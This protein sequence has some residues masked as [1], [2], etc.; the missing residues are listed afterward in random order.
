M[1]EHYV[2]GFEVGTMKLQHRYSSQAR[3]SASGKSGAEGVHRKTAPQNQAGADGCRN[4]I[5]HTCQQA[6]DAFPDKM[7]RVVIVKQKAK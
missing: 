3:K 5:R 4:G 1:P 7:L 6:F 2:R